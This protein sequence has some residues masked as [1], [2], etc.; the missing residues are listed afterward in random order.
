MILVTFE[1]RWSMGL[2]DLSLAQIV[3]VLEAV[4]ETLALRNEPARD[5]VQRAENILRAQLGIPH[6]E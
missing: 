3:T 1:G 2:E 5:H 4:G 6:R